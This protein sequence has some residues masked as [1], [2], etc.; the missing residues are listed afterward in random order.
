LLEETVMIRK[1]VEKTERKSAK[2]INI[3]LKKDK[4]G[5]PP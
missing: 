5:G 4:P 2:N 1:K 3:Y